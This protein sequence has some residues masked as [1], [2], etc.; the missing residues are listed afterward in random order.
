MLWFP[1]TAGI[2]LLAI[3]LT[4]RCFRPASPSLFAVI[5][6][7][8]FHV[9]LLI[10]FFLLF[11]RLTPGALGALALIEGAAGVAL[12]WRKSRAAWPAPAWREIFR[13]VRW[14]HVL[15]MVPL[16]GPI[17]AQIVIGLWIGP[18]FSDAVEYHLIAPMRWVQEGRLVWDG[19]GSHEVWHPL[20]RAAGFPKTGAVTAF[21]HMVFARDLFPGALAQ[22]SWALLGLAAVYALG[23][24]A[25]L[26][27]R[28]AMAVV[29]AALLTPESLLQLSEAYVDLTH[30]SLVMAA[31]LFVFL[32]WRRGCRRWLLLAALAL[33]LLG[34]VKAIGVLFCGVLGALL[35]AA[36]IRRRWAARR[37]A[38]GLAIVAGAGL[39]LAG[40]W[41]IHNVIKFDNLLYPQKLSIMG[42]TLGD[43]PF[44]KDTFF[45]MFMKRRT[46]SYLE[47]MW[48][49]WREDQAGVGLAPMWSGMGAAFFILGLPGLLAALA[50]AGME[51]HRPVLIIMLIVALLYLVQPV[52]WHS[53]YSLY[54]AWW[55]II[56]ALW[57]AQGLSRPERWLA[58]ALLAVCLMYQGVK[59]APAA[60][61]KFYPPDFY[62]YALKTG[63]V[64]PLRF[65]SWPGEFT[66]RHY[67]HEN[68]AERDLTIWISPNTPALL[69]MPRDMTP[70][71]VTWD[72]GDVRAWRE[73]LRREG[74]D[75][76]YI[77]RS[78][79]MDL[80][81]PLIEAMTAAPGEFELEFNYRQ[82]G[83]YRGPYYNQPIVEQ[84][85]YRVRAAGEAGEAEP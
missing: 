71:L 32:F 35:V 39:A 48:I 6:L 29:Y 72:T 54:F 22:V 56:A 58:G 68:L 57:F 21:W 4:R 61:S 73:R 84:F 8:L 37:I 33:G 10:N 9:I 49:S 52:K 43:G 60:A 34:G 53:R 11:W 75:Y 20:E 25:G 47:A 7:T 50:R 1:A 15:A 59:I 80:W 76:V 36:M 16:G 77:E 82:E 65:L 81:D 55:A 13:N 2:L 27:R 3:G 14:R 31:V 66:G 18:R 70:R 38:G 26:R 67:I 46:E 41:Y 64:S 28:W 83:L 12:L 85:L 51:R 62:H 24:E 42:R 17:V 44:E 78:R 40:P 23:R 45:P 74:A 5:S 79:G 19:I 69:A 63:D 30:S